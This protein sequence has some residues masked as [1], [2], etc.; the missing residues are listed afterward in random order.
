MKT[1]F[2]CHLDHASRGGSYSFLRSLRKAL[3][4]LGR[5]AETPEAADIVLAHAYVDVS[6][7]MQFKRRHPS[8]PVVHRVDGPVQLHTASSAVKDRLVWALGRTLADGVIYQSQWSREQNLAMG[9]TP[10]PLEAVIW[11]APDPQDFHPPMAPPPLDGKTRIL[12]TSWSH[13]WSKGYDVYR[14]LD[15]MLDFS[16]Y[17]L[18]VVGNS[19]AAFTHI[20]QLPPQDHTALG[21]ILRQ[22]HVYLTASKAEACSNALLEALHCGLPALGRNSGSTP[23]LIG[24]GGAIFET[25]Q[26]IPALLERLTARHAAYAAAIHVPSLDEIAA[27]YLEFME[28]VLEQASASF[29]A[30]RERASLTAHTL[31]LKGYQRLPGWLLR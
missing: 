17:E 16:R 12:V 1:H 20:R 31:M 3:R 7:V 28:R 2:L 14:D 13:N 27:Q 22:H 29:P 26:E 30:W 23:E 10:C 4:Q 11:N 8:I 19:P 21:E 15:A 5:Y 9:A 18:T 24:G 6:R 25:A